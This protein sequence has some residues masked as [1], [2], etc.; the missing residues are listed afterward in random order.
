MLHN[1][2]C[3]ITLIPF[4]VQFLIN[5]FLSEIA[6]I[7]TKHFCMK[8]NFIYCKISTSFIYSINNNKQS[9]PSN[10]RNSKEISEMFSKKDSE[11]FELSEEIE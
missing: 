4:E 3:Y 11:N 6:S 10:E 5:H 1:N 2:S 7:S 8:K 9:S